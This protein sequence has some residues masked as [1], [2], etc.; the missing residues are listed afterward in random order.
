MLE[1]M[2]S[3]HQNDTYELSEQPE[4]KNAI[5]YKWV[6]AKKHEFQDG[7]TIRCKSRLIAKAYAQKKG[8]D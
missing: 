7:E 3:L 1:E 8:I 5:G 4:G 2:N 6:F